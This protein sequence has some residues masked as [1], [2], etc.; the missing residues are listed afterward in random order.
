MKR[1]KSLKEQLI[2]VDI[3][4]DGLPSDEYPEWEGMTDNITDATIQAK[5]F[6]K[7]AKKLYRGYTGEAIISKDGTIVKVI[8]F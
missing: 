8:K 1:Y 6:I 7:Q 4:I 5:E 3:T 2:H